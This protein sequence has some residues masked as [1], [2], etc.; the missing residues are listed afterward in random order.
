MAVGDWIGLR[1]ETGGLMPTTSFANVPFEGTGSEYHSGTG[2]TYNSGTDDVTVADAGHYFVAYWFH[3]EADDDRLN[4]QARVTVDGTESPGS[5]ATGYA[6]AA[7]SAADINCMV[8]G[9]CI[10]RTT[11]ASSEIAVQ[12]RRD[13]VDG[14]TSPPGSVD[15]QSGVVIVRLPD[16]GDAEYGY[17][18][19]NADA[20]T[21]D[22]TSVSDAT[23]ATTTLETDTAVIEKQAGNSAI[24]CKDAG[25]Y[26]VSYGLTFE[27]GSNVRTSRHAFGRI[28]GLSPFF[29]G[30][31]SWTQIRSDS[32]SG[33]RYGSLNGAFLYEIGSGSEP[34]DIAIAATRHAKT[35]AAGT[36]SNT[37]LTVNGLQ[38]CRLPSRVKGAIYE[39]TT[40]GQDVSATPP[41][42]LNL[43]RTTNHQDTPP[44]ASPDNTNLNVGNV[45][46]IIG[47]SAVVLR[48][49]ETA[50]ARLSRG[51]RFE[52]E[53]VDSDD[54]V[55]GSHMRGDQGSAGIFI[56]AY[57][58]CA[59]F[60]F[61]ADDTVNIETIDFG[62]DGHTSDLTGGGAR[63]GVWAVSIDSL[64]VTSADTD[65]VST[66]SA[67][68]SFDAETDGEA[69]FAASGALFATLVGSAGA[70]ASQEADWLPAA[71]LT[72]SF[73]TESLSSSAI[74]GAKVPI[75]IP[76][77]YADGATVLTATTA[78]ATAGPELMFKDRRSEFYRTQDAV[79][80]VS[81]NIDLGQNRSITSLAVLDIEGP[82]NLEIKLSAYAADSEAALTAGP[83]DELAVLILIP[84]LVDN[85][86]HFLY[87]SE[88]P[89]NRRYLRIVV[90]HTGN[91]VQQMGW[92]RVMLGGEWRPEEGISVGSGL[93]TP[94]S[95]SEVTEA[96]SGSRFVR[97][98][99]RRRRASPSFEVEDE[100]YLGDLWD[101][102]AFSG[103]N[104]PLYYCQDASVDITNQLELNKQSVYGLVPD[105][106][107]V[108]ARFARQYEVG[109]DLE[110]F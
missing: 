82:A 45:D 70:P 33:S 28:A 18:T 72:A 86:R 37:D 81:A 22:A 49:T 99:Y 29:P 68:V 95:A 106:S 38:V 46:A 11:A 101:L 21:F 26:L 25:L 15:S 48:G 97:H 62:S 32:S 27:G 39:D 100:A 92:S 71:S 102:L 75:F 54:G 98:L 105:Q 10:V 104:R 66:P 42:D 6:G 9:T 89:I 85:S 4:I 2:F 79:A 65:L 78:A 51:L 40:A 87:W 43:F 20:Q 41:V 47:A 64:A 13:T 63:N 23:W 96:V 80:T 52:I 57:N 73:A 77:S 14:G 83:R 12:W 53:G 7:L 76:A 109:F 74:T 59:A 36:I 58:P 103:S 24:R 19:K 108:T 17:Y 69:I 44:F 5:R 1:E 55:S 31:A 61:S 60:D 3:V 84:L 90:Q 50:T 8:N 30:S 34:D 110:E 35:E 107:L 91:P 88:T 94:G 56:T 16:A 67:T 93:V